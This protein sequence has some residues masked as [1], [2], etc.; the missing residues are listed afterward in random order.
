[1]GRQKQS[2]RDLSSKP[3]FLIGSALSDVSPKVMKPGIPWSPSLALTVGISSRG[4]VLGHLR[5]WFSK[6][7]GMSVGNG[8]RSKNTDK[9]LSRERRPV[10]SQK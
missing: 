10:V 5:E 8:A 7:K 2:A 1:M 4:P 9:K 3:F 6:R